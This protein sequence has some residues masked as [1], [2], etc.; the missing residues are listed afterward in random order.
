[1]IDDQPRRRPSAG[2]YVVLWR[3]IEHPRGWVLAVDDED[4]SPILWAGDAAKALR[5]AVHAHPDLNRAVHGGACEVVAIPAA[6]WRPVPTH[7]EQPPPRVRFGAP[8]GT[9]PTTDTTTMEVST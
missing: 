2:H 4:G 8:D 5:A 6:S 1:M 3:R 9:E 7:L